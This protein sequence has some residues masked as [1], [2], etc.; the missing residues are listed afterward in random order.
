MLVNLHMPLYHNH[1]FLVDQDVLENILID[2]GVYPIQ[3]MVR[4]YVK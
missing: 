4:K 3:S 2:S 1:S